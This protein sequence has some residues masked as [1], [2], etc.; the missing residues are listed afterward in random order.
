MTHETEH[1]GSPD[2]HSR[3]QRQLEHWRDQ[4]A[5]MDALPQL[6]L[7]GLLTGIL[8]GIVIVVFVSW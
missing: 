8:A 7:L 5:S 1:T 6:T 2:L 4:M 3:W